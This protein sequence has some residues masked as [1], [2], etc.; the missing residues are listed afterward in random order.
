[1]QIY[2]LLTD[3]C[4][5]NCKMCIR[6]RQSGTNID[7]T[8]LKK[9]SGINDLTNHDIVVT[10]GE[11]T[12]HKDFK[13]IVALLLE[14]TRTV[15]ITT[16]GTINEY[17]TDD[18]L[19]DNL[20][21]QVSIDGDIERHNSIRGQGNYEKSLITIKK[22]DEMGAKYSVA[23]V[24]SYKNKESMFI[25]E[26]E[27]RKLKNI[28]YW[29][30]SYEM[31]FG[32]AESDDFMSA[33]E[34]NVFVDKIIG[35]ARLKLK[36]QKIFPFEVYERRWDELDL[37]YSKKQRCNN[38]G[39]GSEK[40]Y[41]YPDWTVYSCT[42]L[43]DFSL[44]NLKEKTIEEILLSNEI[45]RFSEYEVQ[46]PICLQCRYLKYCNGGCI[47]MSYHYYGKLGMGDKRCPI[48]KEKERS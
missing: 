34:W 13:E 23:S 18:F 33:E 19:H 26:K 12:L 32:D 10:G 6:G 40:I 37:I 15:T 14:K 38:C 2:L 20:F 1:M 39:S 29:R 11:P 21:F 3:N 44:G 30:I 42:C 4:N 35:E 31:P 27:L 41:I 45:K 36:I 46:N 22:L 47:G 24:V 7:V 17:L 8:D 28:R 5:L 25:L 43:T 48:I 9:M 16:N